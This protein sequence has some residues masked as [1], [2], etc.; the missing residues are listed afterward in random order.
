MKEFDIFPTGP[1]ISRRA[2][3]GGVLSTTA[4]LSACGSETP[5]P[6]A[7][8][9]TIEAPSTPAEDDIPYICPQGTDDPECDNYVG[10]N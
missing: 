6:T 4:L 7:V 5:A 8:T 10:D 1:K 3:I 2:L 9:P